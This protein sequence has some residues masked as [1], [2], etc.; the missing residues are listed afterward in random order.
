MRAPLDP[1]DT[2]GISEIYGTVLIISLV[3]LVAFS[4]VGVGVFI[5]GDT[6]ADAND[7][8]AQDAV[9]ELD[10]RV[11]ALTADRVE[12]SITWEVPQ[13]TAEDFEANGTRGTINVTVRTNDTYWTWGNSSGLVDSPVQANAT[14]EIPLGTITHRSEDG[15]LTVYQGG[16]VFEI[17]D[18]TVTVL[19]EPEISVSEGNLDLDFVNLSSVDQIDGSELTAT[20]RRTQPDSAEIQQI[21][22]AQMRRD[23]NLVAPARVN[24]TITSEFADGWGALVRE[25]VESRPVTVWDHTDLPE[26]ATNQVKIGFGEFGRG[27]DLPDERSPYAPGV[28][29]SGVADLA[30]ELYNWSA[31]TIRERAG[32]FNVSANGGNEYTVGLRYDHDGDGADWWKLNA[33]N[34]W[35]NIEDPMA[36][37]LGPDE[38]RP[39]SVDPANGV[40]RMDDDAWTC[41]VSHAPSASEPLRSQVNR[42]GSGCFVDPVGV[43]NPDDSVA[44][45]SPLLEITGLSVR[46]PAS[47]QLAFGTDRLQVAVNVTNTG[48]GDADSGEPTAMLADPDGGDPWVADGT[49]LNASSP[50]SR[51]ESATYSFSY[52]PQFLGDRFRVRAGTPDDA[53]GNDTW[54]EITKTPDAEPFEIERVTVRNSPI[55]AGDVLKVDVTVN[56]TGDS[57]DEQTVIL[58]DRA[59]PQATATYN[60]SAGTERTKTIE[61]DTEVGDGNRSNKSI[62][63]S[64]LTDR[65][66]ATAIIRKPGLASADF[67][68]DRVEIDDPVTEGN[69]LEAEATIT[70][71]GSDTG[72]RTVRLR[73]DNGVIRATVP[74][75]TLDPGETVTLGSSAPPLVWE[76]DTGDTGVYDLTVETDDD[77]NTTT[78]VEI[79]TPTGVGTFNVS[80]AESGLDDVI[81]GDDLEVP[82]TIEYNGGGTRTESIWLTDFDGEPVDARTVSL[83]S[84]SSV[85][86]TL[87]WETEAGDGQH[88]PGTITANG[89]DDTDSASV[90]VRPEDEAGPSYTITSVSTNSSVGSN[91]SLPP[92]PTTEGED[93]EINVTVENSGTVLGTES[94]VVEYVPEDRPVATR[95]VSIPSG[96]SKTVTLTWETVVGDNTTT[97]SNP[98]NAEDI[99]I[100]VAGETARETVFIDNRTVRRDPVDVM[101]A[102]DETGSMGVP[103]AYSRSGMEP[104]PQLTLGAQATGDSYESNDE[105]GAAA[106]IPT[107]T[108]ADLLIANGE[109]DYFAVTLNETESLDAA[110]GFDDDAGNLELELYGPTQRLLDSSRSSGEGE[111]VSVSDVTEAGTYYVRVYGDGTDSAEY[112]LFVQ[113]GDRSNDDYEPNDDIGAAQPLGSGEYRD[114]RIANAESDFFAVSL[115][116]SESLRGS[117]DFDNDIGDLDLVLYDPEG[118]LIDAGYGSESESVSVSNVSE[119]GTY[120]L[121]VY[122]DDGASAPYALD[123]ETGRSV[124]D[125]RFSYDSPLFEEPVTP[126]GEEFLYVR[127]RNEIY[128]QGEQFDIPYRY[129]SKVW[130]GKRLT[131]A[132]DVPA[133]ADLWYA[134]PE[135]GGD[136]SGEVENPG[137]E[138]TFYVSGQ[139]VDPAD[140]GGAAYVV[141]LSDRYCSALCYD[142]TGQRYDAVLAALS[143]L[144]QP[145]GDRAGLLEFNLS[146]N[147]YQ[148]LTNN[149]SAVEQSLRV[150][151]GGGTDITNAILEAQEQLNRTA[152]PNR[153]AIV[154][155]TDGE[156]NARDVAPPSE[157]VD[158]IADNVT[159]YVVGFGSA[160]TSSDGELATVANAG[161][162]EGK[163]YDGNDDDLEEIFAQIGEELDEPDLPNVQVNTDS[164]LQVKE[165][166]TLQVPVG[167][168]NTGAGGERIIT[169]T[170][171]YGNIVDSTTVSLAAGERINAS[172]PAAPVLEWD[173]DLQGEEPPTSGELLVRTPSS[174][175]TPNVTVTEGDPS[176]FAVTIQ[177]VT[178]TD[179]QATD[180]INVTARI[181][182]RLPGPDTQTVVL[183]DDEGNPVDVQTVRL[184]GADG[185]NSATTTSFT[186]KTRPGDSGTGQTLTVESDDTADTTTVDIDRAP[187]ADDQ[188]DVEI[189]GTT[190]PTLA[191]NETDVEVRVE[192]VGSDPG[193]QF[194]E[195]RNF[196][197]N[198]VDLV[199]T[200]TLSPGGTETY[201][202][203][204]NTTVGDAGTGNVYAVTRD[205]ADGEAVTIRQVTGPNSTFEIVDADAVNSTVTAGD[206]VEITAEI[207]NTGVDPDSQFVEAT[208]DTV[209]K[210]ANISDLDPGARSTV[211]FQF[212]TATG[213]VNSSQTF[214]IDL[215]TEDDNETVSVTVEPAGAP[216]QVDIVGTGDPVRAGE[217]LP[218]T[219]EVTGL[220]STSTLSLETPYGGALNPTNITTIRSNGT[221]TITWPTL[222]GQG[223]PNPQSV[224]ARVRGRTSD[225]AAVRVE[226]APEGDVVAPGTGPSADPVGIDIDEIEIN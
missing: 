48:T 69:D 104:T 105:L 35:V 187:G 190:A 211:T 106:S 184:D 75:L 54:W 108:Y 22:D 155:L 170:D 71:D 43:E 68:I 121:R 220:D 146:Q 49:R 55:V 39:V 149:L 145:L 50:L 42:T 102:I 169:V 179:P 34:Q 86:R 77:T 8:L 4:L 57:R 114:L 151:P 205:D 25:A 112:D 61:W 130:P 65:E 204:W 76:T 5:L 119:A 45:F 30:P 87:V 131:N 158:E 156:H 194:V 165:G 196:D 115:N 47:K 73:D 218:V 206:P 129:R 148:P 107:G 11:S 172:D 1:T 10:D 167:V 16:G 94:V 80:I 128:E 124:S 188:F 219:V 142:S 182:N 74:D 150:N 132:T 111:S 201:T 67:E 9:L 147:V 141:N 185:P 164:T 38:P 19:R 138:G 126:A 12:N 58:S 90:E 31:G 24:L 98:R 3:F 33:S 120:Y 60:L 41:V 96:A 135:T 159:V 168:E 37:P 103:A 118:D 202:L 136:V 193:Q 79:T 17:Q 195:L 140:H 21:V 123:I 214:D 59:G 222:P 56:N 144:S 26:L 81:A 198:T 152:D 117:I 200:R 157:R 203:T 46:G 216:L 207:E 174:E 134:L 171:I 109:S 6:T 51:G 72:T 14:G 116:D 166:E 160:D 95:E 83:T 110:I 62:N 178:P 53:A 210:T 197:N 70:N 29:Y 23:G 28:I 2:R 40:F 186:W 153:K 180:E 93:L 191:G 183:R 143:S 225:P 177:S 223:D 137:T 176:E 18:G 215:E 7:R 139:T 175:A 63:I 221:Y 217:A 89:V 84:G 181:E 82:V 163:L 85:R 209:T 192:N 154:L 88:A 36:A 162:G 99:E 133:E 100:R 212:G 125:E 92:D 224:V 113:S 226:E 91:G 66:S 173:A 97:P 44:E 20:Q 208:F 199:E 64:T 122:G 52:T 161:T 127:Q 15:V 13:G 27:V 32:G 213:A 78:D 189:T 101:F